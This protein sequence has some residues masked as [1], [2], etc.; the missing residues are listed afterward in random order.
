MMCSVNAFLQKFPDICTLHTS[1]YRAE[2][3]RSFIT[4][5]V[6]EESQVT[7]QER[8][9]Y[10]SNWRPTASSSM[11]LPTLTSDNRFIGNIGWIAIL[12][13]NRG[14]W[15]LHEKIQAIFASCDGGSS[16][17]QEDWL[18]SSSDP[19]NRGVGIQVT[20]VMYAPREIICW[21]C[22]HS[23]FFDCSLAVYS[24]TLHEAQFH[25]LVAVVLRA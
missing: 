2:V 13:G 21:I 23:T 22:R 9:R 24:A 25:R 18:N 20:E 19:V 17:R 3:C 10:G 11:P 1:T 8:H 14:D 16:R 4:T 15:K 5:T 7:P 12:P 6:R